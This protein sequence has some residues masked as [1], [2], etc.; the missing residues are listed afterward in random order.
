MPSHRLLLSLLGAW[1]LAACHS[2]GPLGRGAA[3]GDRPGPRNFPTVV[4]DAGHG[5]RDSG[6][7]ARGLTEKSLALDIAKRLADLLRPDF[8]VILT[9]SYD[10]FI[11]LDQRAQTASR[12]SEAVLVSIHLNH[13][14]R[15]R[16]GPETY[17][18]RVDSYSLARRMQRHLSGVCPHESGNAGLVRRRLRLTRN[19]TIPCVLVECGYLTNLKDARLL[20]ATAYRQQIAR[21]LASALREQTLAGDAG[22]GPLPAPIYAPPSKATDAR[23]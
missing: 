4:I 15:W 12:Q 14:R 8:R 10:H 20:A 18:W 9:R 16:A 3:Y 13:G 22:M 11:E 6:A 23:G 1:L 7:R 5:G 17:W 2:I 21:A 19:P